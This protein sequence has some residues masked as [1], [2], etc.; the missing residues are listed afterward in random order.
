[1]NANNNKIQ[2]AC[3]DFSVDKLY[4]FGSFARNENTKNSDID[5]LVSFKESIPTNYF[6]NFFD[7][8]F[9]LEEIFN[10]KV[11]LISENTLKNPY[12]IKSINAD[13]II[14]YGK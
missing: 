10:K 12:L 3:K 5:F 6:D 14:I 11:D 7:F 8:Q 1:M 13:K 9:K 4:V 2:N